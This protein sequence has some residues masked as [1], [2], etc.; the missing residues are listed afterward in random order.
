MNTSGIT[1]TGFDIIVVCHVKKDAKDYLKFDLSSQSVQRRI[2]KNLIGMTFQ[3]TSICG[4]NQMFMLLRRPKA[5]KVLGG[6]VCLINVRFTQVAL[7]W[8]LWAPYA[9]AGW[10][11]IF[12][13]ILYFFQRLNH[14][15]NKR[16]REMDSHAGVLFNTNWYRQ[17]FGWM[18]SSAS[19]HKRVI[20]IYSISYRAQQPRYKESITTWVN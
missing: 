20:K 15:S 6:D 11:M 19:Y 10:E 14:C 2:C 5:G 13:F 4:L 16:G 9:C 17:V 8:F 7:M 18:T 12:V 1:V 3:T